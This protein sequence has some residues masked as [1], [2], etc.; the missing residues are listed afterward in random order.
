M[1]SEAERGSSASL[2]TGSDG[3][4]APVNGLQQPPFSTTATTTTTTALA[5]S[6][7]TPTPAHALPASSPDPAQVKVRYSEE[8]SAG[9]ANTR[10]MHVAPV[11]QGGRGEDG[12]GE[13]A[14]MTMAEQTLVEGTVGGVGEEGRR[15]HAKGPSTSSL[16]LPTKEDYISKKSLDRH[17]RDGS[18]GGGARRSED[19]PKSAGT[20]TTGATWDPLKHEEVDKTHDTII[21][22]DDGDDVVDSNGKLVYPHDQ[23]KPASAVPPR[24]ASHLRLD[25]KPASPTPWERVE[26]PLDNNLKAIAGYYS[27]VASQKFQT[28]Q[29]PKWVFLLFVYFLDFLLIGHGQCSTFDT[30]IFLLFWTSTS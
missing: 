12:E 25:I 23:V 14:S 28:F 7:S 20:T 30:Q 21:V 29:N 11:G 3:H 19:Q 22:E 26:P 10:V 4:T 13:L 15:T 6:T 24:R 8:G 18:L 5:T 17:R 1:M 2:M 16:S 27:P 9:D